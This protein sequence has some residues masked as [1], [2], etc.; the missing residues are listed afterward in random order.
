M[1]SENSASQP[2]RHGYNG[3]M[4]VAGPGVSAQI[5]V[6]E[7]EMD[8]RSAL[9]DILELSGFSAAPVSNGKEAL[10]YLRTSIRPSLI[11]LDLMMPEMDGWQFRAEQKKDAG[12]AAVPVVVIT[13]FGGA[14]IDANEILVK[15]VDVDRLLNIV[16]RYVKPVH[17]V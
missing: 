5:L 11:I 3:G 15:P 13:A 8:A 9:V 1:H 14:I 10:H 4:S 7:D 17:P 16:S 12:L 6:V 2:L